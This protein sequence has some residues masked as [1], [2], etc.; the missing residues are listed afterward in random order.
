MFNKSAY[1]VENLQTA[2]FGK[3]TKFSY[4]WMF[5][6][7]YFMEEKRLDFTITV[8]QS[9][10]FHHKTFYSFVLHSKVM[11]IKLSFFSIFINIAVSFHKLVSDMLLNEYNLLS[12]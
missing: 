8:S 3:R 10:D 7:F 9:L 11:E 2:A 4:H 1:F 12:E 6:L 5:P